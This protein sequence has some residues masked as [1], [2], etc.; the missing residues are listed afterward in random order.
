MIEGV[1]NADLEAVLAI[2]LL[3]PLD[4]Q[5]EIE[6]VI[7]TG[8]NGS[9]T[10]PPEIIQA[11]NLPWLY[12]QEGE[13]ADRSFHIFDVH[14]GAIIWNDLTRVVEIEAASTEPLVGMELLEN[15]DLSIVVR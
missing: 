1:V 5:H 13:L 11:L 6:A 8:F 10:L 12:R 9:L 2:T 4:T 15:H 7:D 14:E 3:G